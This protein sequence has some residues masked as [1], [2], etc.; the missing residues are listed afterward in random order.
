MKYLITLAFAFVACTTTAQQ[1]LPAEIQIKTALMAAPAD[2]KDSAT[3]L[4]YDKNG[5][6]VTLR[7]GNGKMICIADDPK[8]EGISVSCYS[9]HLEP[10]MARGRELLAEG[11]TEKEKQDI[12][13]KEID[14]G[15]IIM[16]KDPNILYVLTGTDENYDKKT[17][18]LKDA[19]LRWVFYV[20]Y[21]TLES[22]GMSARP[23]TPGMPWLMD[24]GTPKAHIMITPPRKQQ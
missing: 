2:M 9:A 4:G 15:K 18:E 16:P 1:V 21:A 11:R 19:H 13:N 12:R 6:I 10:F 22:T 5:N 8:K 3:I 23:S 20:P 14:D 17:G 7:P 24:P